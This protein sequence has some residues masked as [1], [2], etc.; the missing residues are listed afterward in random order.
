MAHSKTIELNFSLPTFQIVIIGLVFVTFFDKAFIV[1]IVFGTTMEA[2]TCFG[3]HFQCFLQILL[4]QCC[5]NGNLVKCFVS[6]QYFLAQY[7]LIWID[8]I[9][10]VSSEIKVISGDS[11][12]RLSPGIKNTIGKWKT[13]T[14]WYWDTIY[15]WQ[16]CGNL[17]RTLHK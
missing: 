5:Q 2:V 4:H 14:H 11:G 9:T 13:I 16:V 3:F 7:L 8:K 12:D 6:F 17:S 1:V 15:K 10:G